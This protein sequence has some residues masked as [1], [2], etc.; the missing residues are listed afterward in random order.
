MLTKRRTHVFDRS[1]TVAFCYMKFSMI[2]NLAPKNLLKISKEFTIVINLTPSNAWFEVVSLRPC[3]RIF[4]SLRPKNRLR[5][6]ALFTQWQSRHYIHLQLI[7]A[8][9]LISVNL[10]Y[11]YSKLNDSAFKLIRLIESDN[12]LRFIYEL[13]NWNERDLEKSLKSEL[14]KKKHLQKARREQC[15]GLNYIVSFSSPSFSILSCRKF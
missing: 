6:R 9:D 10:F 8:R 13:D 2:K 3:I 1:P 4:F 5:I 12:L 15:R 14:P 11:I 7:V